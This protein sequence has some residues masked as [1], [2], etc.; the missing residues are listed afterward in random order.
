[1]EF[2]TELPLERGRHQLRVAAV[3]ADAAKT[4]LVITPVEV[5]EP[6]RQL[7]MAPPLVLQRVGERVQ[8]KAARRF[9]SGA[10]LGVQAEVAGRP[11]QDGKAV[12]KLSV[13]DSS[14]AVVRTA[15]AAID[16]AGASDRRRATALV[17]TSGLAPGAYL[18]TLEAGTGSPGS[19]MDAGPVST[20][21]VL[22][23]SVVAHGPTSS[24]AEPGTFVIRDEATWRRFWRTLP[25]RQSA[26]EIDFSRATLFAV[27]GGPSDGPSSK[28]V[29]VS[30]Y[31]EG[32]QT[33]VIWRA[34]ATASST[35]MKPFTVVAMP[36]II[37]GPVRFERQQ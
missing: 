31:E 9:V 23:H 22:R 11:V 24:H 17:D 35:D 33:M 32:G 21:G 15:D 6:G 16:A 25:T 12:V 26:P 37:E 30:V 8:P 27:V 1:M 7:L 28:P 3:T 36:R 10:A 14:G 18:L 13:S 19:E 5:I 4:G 2:T 20:A 34:D 29:V